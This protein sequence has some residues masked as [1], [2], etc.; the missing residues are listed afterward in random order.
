MQLIFWKYPR[1]A[2]QS[3]F[4][5]LQELVAH[6]MAKELDLS[7]NI[8]GHSCSLHFTIESKIPLHLSSAYHSMAPL[9]LGLSSCSQ[10]LNMFSLLPILSLIPWFAPLIQSDGNETIQCSL[11]T[12][13]FLFLE[14]FC[15]GYPL[16]TLEYLLILGMS[17]SGRHPRL[18]H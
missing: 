10:Q 3:L 5:C 6:L 9:P 13:Q 4:G 14:H 16:F 8:F 7:L 2:I 1:A 12:C 11:L 17:L 15:Q 18:L